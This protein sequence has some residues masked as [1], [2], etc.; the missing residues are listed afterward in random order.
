MNAITKRWI[1]RP[2]WQGALL[3]AA[4]LCALMHLTGCD[5]KEE[6]PDAAVAKDSASH[7]KDGIAGD[8]HGD[9]KA[10]VSVI[11]A[12]ALKGKQCKKNSEC[13]GLMCVEGYC[14]DTSCAGPCLTCKIKGEEGTCGPVPVGTTNAGCGG[15]FSCSVKGRCLLGNGESCSSSS[16]CAS[17]YCKD[18]VCCEEA[19]TTMCRNCSTGKCL[20]IKGNSDP[21][22]CSGQ[23]SCD[24][25]GVCK[26]QTGSS[27][28]A[29]SE[30]LS[31]FC[32]DGRCCFTA[33]TASCQD[34]T[35]GQCKVVSYAQD[36]PECSGSK[37]C[38]KAGACM[39]AL[40]QKCT[41]GTECASGFCKEGVCCDKACTAPC[42]SCTTGKCLAV[43][44]NH[45]KQSLMEADLVVGTLEAVTVDDLSG[46][47]GKEGL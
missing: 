46:L 21:P 35:T 20:A 1:S 22:E 16:I 29:A 23:T 30:C 4:A 8:A 14:C 45:T 17:G 11:E 40:G 37:I 42:K 31:G 47:F 34:C 38:G 41:A 10:D 3:A 24:L 44:S 32:K 27:C 13:A 25:S 43:T 36:I 9:G 33:C 12:G 28:S 7:L 2:P 5:N 15:S 19:C 6:T 26:G 39:S 18:G